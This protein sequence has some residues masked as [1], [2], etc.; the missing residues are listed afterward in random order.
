M[1]TSTLISLY[2]RETVPNLNRCLN[3]IYKQHIKTDEVVIVI[4]GIIK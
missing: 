1:K 4:D 2:F 3:S